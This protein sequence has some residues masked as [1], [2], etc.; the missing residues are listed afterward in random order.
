MSGAVNSGQVTVLVVLLMESCQVS[1]KQDINFV[2][3]HLVLK[4]NVERDLTIIIILDKT[5]NH[6]GS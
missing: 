4:M 6:D 3:G 2:L 5:L 1:L